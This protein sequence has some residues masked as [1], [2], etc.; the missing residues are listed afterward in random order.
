MDESIRPENVIVSAIYPSEDGY[1]T[2]F[3]VRARRN[4]MEVTCRMSWEQCVVVRSSM[5]FHVGD[6]VIRRRARHPQRLPF[7]EILAIP[8]MN[9]IICDDNL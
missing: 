5:W 3:D 4:R 7:S 9:M 2:C 8:R 1:W 6:I